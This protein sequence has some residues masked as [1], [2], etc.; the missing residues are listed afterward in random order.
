MKPDSFEI[1]KQIKE[2]T[3]FEIGNRPFHTDKAQLGTVQMLNALFGESK[4][5]GY[6]VVTD[7]HIYRVLIEN[8]QNCCED[9]GYFSSNDSGFEC[10]IGKELIGVHLI[11]TALNTIK[12]DDLYLDQGDI[13]F[14]DFD[15][16]DGTKL[17]LAVYN[18]HNGYYGHPIFILKDDIILKQD[19]L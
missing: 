6:E 7:Q 1:V 19:T 2:I 9:W 4:Y 3:D 12:V 14:V 11:D 13:Q 15:F 8:E 5:D 16:S 17:Q 18:A 10:Y